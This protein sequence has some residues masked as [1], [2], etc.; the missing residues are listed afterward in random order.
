MHALCV[1][2][3]ARSGVHGAGGAC[4]S[5]EFVKICAFV[6]VAARCLIMCA[7]MWTPVLCR[8]SKTQGYTHNIKSNDLYLVF[9]AW[10]G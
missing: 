8:Y 9:E 3:T 6:D 7:E 4:I 2:V 10:R 1:H 5:D